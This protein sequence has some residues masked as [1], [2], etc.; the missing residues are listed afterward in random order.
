MRAPLRITLA[1]L[2]KSFRVAD[3]LPPPSTI[4]DETISWKELQEK[5]GSIVD[6]RFLRRKSEIAQ[7]IAKLPGYRH[8][9]EPE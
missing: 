4:G 2:S 8:D 1:T 5:Y 6:P 9:G 7:T 3:F